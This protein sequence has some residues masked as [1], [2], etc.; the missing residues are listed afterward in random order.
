MGYGNVTHPRQDRQHHGGEYCQGQPSPPV[1]KEEESQYPDQQQHITQE[2]DYESGEEFTQFVGVAV[3][4]FY[5]LARGVVVVERHIQ[6]QAVLREVG[7]ECV[8]G[9][10]TDAA[11]HV[12]GQNAENLLHDRYDGEEHT[13]PDQPADWTSDHSLVDEI[14]DYLRV[15]EL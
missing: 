8:C 1:L 5:H 15:N 9:S 10:P 12:R 11:T 3:D 7:P 6:R 14:S 2:G 13:G 4:S